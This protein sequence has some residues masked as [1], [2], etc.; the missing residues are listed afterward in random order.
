M[1]PDTLMR[2]Y[3]TAAF[4]GVVLLVSALLIELFFLATG[5]GKEHRITGFMCFAGFALTLAALIT[6]F[7]FVITR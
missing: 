7:I 3:L 2:I 1:N 4:I 6:N 5:D